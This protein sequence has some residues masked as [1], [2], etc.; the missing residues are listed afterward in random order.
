MK[1]QPFFSPLQIYFYAKWQE[2]EVPMSYGSLNPKHE[3]RNP[4]QT[5]MT[6]NANNQLLQ[7]AGKRVFNILHWVI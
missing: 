7:G 6:K 4:K 1:A 5:R 3:N 2:V